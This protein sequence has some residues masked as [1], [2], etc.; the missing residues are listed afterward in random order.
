MGSPYVPAAN[1]SAPGG[2][3]SRG[4]WPVVVRW[5]C[6]V[7]ACLLV[8]W[9][10]FSWSSAMRQERLADTAN[11]QLQLEH[12]V[13]Q[14]LVGEWSGIQ[15]IEFRT[16]T[17]DGWTQRGI[18]TS[19]LVNGLRMSI[20]VGGY[21]TENISK[22]NSS[23]SGTAV[24]DIAASNEGWIAGDPDLGMKKRDFSAG[25]NLV[26]NSLDHIAISYYV[27]Y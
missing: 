27:E 16:Y 14:Y 17:N 18:S 22:D 23:L 2:K 11:R 6:A 26:K 7:T 15:T 9:G 8:M 20:N 21:P 12:M 24:K 4:L 19:F 13:A 1:N 3:T 10:A 5:V 25:G